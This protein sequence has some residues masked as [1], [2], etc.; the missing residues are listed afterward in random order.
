MGA[1]ALMG[2][3]YPP[4][5]MSHPDPAIL[6]QGLQLVGEK[7]GGEECPGVR[8][9]APATAPSLLSARPKAQPAEQERT[10][11]SS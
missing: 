3:T 10:A 8:P 5:A 2:C 1:T 6:L 11:R 9:H 7:L 4:C